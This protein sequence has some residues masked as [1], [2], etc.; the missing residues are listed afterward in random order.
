MTSKSSSTL[1]MAAMVVLTL[2]VVPSASAFVRTTPMRTL[3]SQRIWGTSTTSTTTSSALPMSTTAEASTTAKKGKKVRR[4]F[5]FDIPPPP[6]A[7]ED[8]VSQALAAHEK[9]MEHMKAKDKTSKALSKEELKIVYQDEHIVVVDKPAGVLCVP[10]KAGNPSLAAAVFEAF[11]CES[12]NVDTMVAHRL[13]FDT[14]GLVVFARTDKAIS[15]L[16]VQLRSRKVTKTYEALVCGTVEGD[17]G[18]VD[19]PLARD[20]QAL[21][22]VRVYTQ[23]SQNQLIAILSQL[24]DDHSA[25]KFLK[26]KKPSITEYKVIAQEDLGGNAVTRLALTSVS[27]RTHQLNVHC[28]ALGHPI[29]GDSIYGVGGVASPNGGLVGDLL[30]KNAASTALQ[31]NIDALVKEKQMGLC[32]HLKHLSFKHPITG[33]VLSF[34]SKSPF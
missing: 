27:G 10:D 14:T 22:Y 18:T 24:P 29:V 33:E 21:P 20:I 16:N 6:Q 15:N 5:S 3:P 4:I 30:S 2:A 1:H 11:G 12:G 28:A 34:E 8:E 19:L 17:S 26:N 13:G 7:T 31:Q 32:V 23:E 25:R 9:I